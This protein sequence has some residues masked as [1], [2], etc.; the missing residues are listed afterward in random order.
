VTTKTPKGLQILGQDYKVNTWRDVFEQTIT[1]IADLEPDKV[2]QLMQDYPHFV[3]PDKGR[4]RDPR[5]LPN[6]IFIEVNLSAKAIQ[7]YCTQALSA[8]GL[9]TD[10]WSVE[11]V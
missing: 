3:G 8:I 2:Q 11:L 9:T 7:N 4:F 10:D 6:G 1:T 5:A